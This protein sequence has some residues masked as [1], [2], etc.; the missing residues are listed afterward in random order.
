M[1]ELIEKYLANAKRKRIQ[2]RDIEDYVLKKLSR[3]EYSYAEFVEIIKELL[4]EDKIKAVKARGKN[5]KLPTL[6]NCYQIKESRQEFADEIKN[7]LLA[8]YHPQISLSY[9]LKQKDK[10]EADKKYLKE[11]DSF[12]K[13]NQTQINIPI[14]ERSFQIFN[15]EKFLTSSVGK[16][17]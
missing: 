4:A 5:A 15:D 7:K 9:Y 10:Y 17:F 8:F 12:F 11:L 13:N 14:H 16:R 1:K 2:T 3:Q 6:H